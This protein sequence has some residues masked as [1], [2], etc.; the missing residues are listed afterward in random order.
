MAGPTQ[1]GRRELA[2]CRKYSTG[3]RQLAELVEHP[4]VDAV[5]IATTPGL[6][7]AIAIRALELGKPVFAEKPMAADLAGAEAMARA[8]DSQWPH[9]HGGFQLQRDPGLAQGK[10]AA[11][12]GRDRPLAPTSRS[13]GT[14]RTTGR[15]CASKTGS[16][17]AM[18][19]AACSAI[20]S[21]TASITWN[22][23]CGPIVGMS[24]RLSGLPDEPAMETNAGISMMFRS[25]AAG[26]PRH[27]LRVLSGI[28]PSA[29]I[30]RRG[31]NADADQSTRRTTCAASVECRT[32]ASGAD[33]DRGRRPGG[34]Q[35]PSRRTD[36]AVSRLA[37]AFS[38]ASNAASAPSCVRPGPSRSSLA[39]CRPPCKQRRQL[40]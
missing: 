35:F 12:S 15:G 18:T 37:A 16:R 5:A 3:I 19:A 14:S 27:E 22:G 26:K 10:G 36:R 25:G 30:L 9:D 2:E 34:S 39:R 17:R 7:P 29:G 6:Q 32:P 33:P 40:G 20:L 28:R 21:A 31:R 24:T 13:T 38:M 4:D 11:R 1:R 8:A 23:F